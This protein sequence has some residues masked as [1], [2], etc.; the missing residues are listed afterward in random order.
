M[1]C[2]RFLPCVPAFNAPHHVHSE[3]SLLIKSSSNNQCKYFLSDFAM[4]CLICLEMFSLLFVIVSWLVC[5]AATSM[6]LYILGLYPMA[7][8]WPGGQGQLPATRL[9]FEHINGNQDLLPNY[10]LMLLPY[11]TEVSFTLSI[12]LSPS[13]SHYKSTGWGEC[14]GGGAEAPGNFSMFSIFP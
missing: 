3:K 2:F 4:F 13:T 9:G 10:T 6:P 11:D 14:G 7:G 1:F 8:D 5:R 12:Y